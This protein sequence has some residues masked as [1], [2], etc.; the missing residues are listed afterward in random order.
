M[1]KVVVSEFVTVVW[2]ADAKTF[3]SNVVVLTYEPAGIE[4]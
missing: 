3:G 2:L 1:R 4:G